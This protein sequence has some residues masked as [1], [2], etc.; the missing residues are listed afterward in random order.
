MSVAPGTPFGSPSS[1]PDDEVITVRISVEAQHLEELLEA[2]AGLS[3]PVNPRIDHRHLTSVVEF[4]A[5]PSRLTDV[6]RT[7]KCAGF[8]PRSVEVQQSPRV[9][10]S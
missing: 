8:D 9:L 1:S 6:R 3:F 7:V 10:P 5:A 2:L 4:A